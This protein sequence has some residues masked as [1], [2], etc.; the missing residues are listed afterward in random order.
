MPKKKIFLFFFYVGMI[1]FVNAQ[2]Q[3][4]SGKI[5]NDGGIPIPGVTVTFKETKN[6]TQ[7]MNDGNFIIVIPEKSAIVLVF[8]FIGY[9]TEEVAIK[10]YLPLD[11]T[12]S[13]TTKDIDDVVVIGNGTQRKRDLTESV[14]KV[15]I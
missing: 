13:S 12:L 2:V 6:I 14:E 8:S 10:N 15:N 9:T 3:K 4:I 5:L 1:T 11:V 7:S